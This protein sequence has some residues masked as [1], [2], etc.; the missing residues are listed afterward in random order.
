MDE[1]L[2]EVGQAGSNDRAAGVSEG[3]RVPLTKARILEHALRIVDAEGV[4]AL[5]MRRLAGELGFDTMMLYRHFPNKA[6]IVDGLMEAVFA[7][8]S[9]PSGDGDVS[10]RLLEAAR[11][12]RRVAHAHPHLFTLIAT[13]PVQTWVALQ[14]MEAALQ[15]LKQAG[16]DD[17][18]SV[19]TFFC[20]LAYVYGYALREISTP[21]E[22]ASGMPAWYDPTSVPQQRYPR[23]VELAPYFAS[24]DSDAGFE[25]G[26]GAIFSGLRAKLVEGNS[27]RVGKKGR[28][29]DRRGSQ[30]DARTSS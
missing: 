5:S 8:M 20:A 19:A 23:L 10:E 22:D 25:L 13:R 17:E 28:A 29:K 9:A 15:L 30:S 1:K 7:E 18:G 3:R 2:A 21:P 24:Y 26:L 27:R 4:S 12:F 6:A 16:F 11:A 14:P